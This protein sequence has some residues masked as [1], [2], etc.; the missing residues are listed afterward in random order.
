MGAANVRLGLGVRR[1]DRQVYNDDPPNKLSGELVRAPVD[2]YTNIR[3]DF[4]GDGLRQTLSLNG[5]I[6]VLN[7]NENAPDLGCA[8]RLWNLSHD[9]PIHNADQ[10]KKTASRTA[11]RHDRTSMA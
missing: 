1:R 6:V 11:F 10:R 9:R 7:I 8:R 5:D 4:V 2:P 3:E